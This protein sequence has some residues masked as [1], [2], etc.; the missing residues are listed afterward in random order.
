MK[1]QTK[2]DSLFKKAVELHQSSQHEQAVVLY[3]EVLILNAKHFDALQLLATLHA[4]NAR[5][6]LSAELFARAIEV[7]D[8]NPKV[9]NNYGY[10]LA[11]IGDTRSAQLM[12]E[13]AVKIDSNYLDALNNLANLYQQL[14]SYDRAVELYDRTTKINS[15][16]VQAY[17]NKGIALQKLSRFS[18]SLASYDQAIKLKPDYLDAYLNKALVLKEMGE[19][20]RALNLYSDLLKN[21]TGPQSFDI[22]N[23]CGNLLQSMGN[24]E[25]ALSH[26]DQAVL[27]N[28]YQAVT[29]S[30]RGNVLQRLKRYQEAVLSYV[31]ALT[32]DPQN[33]DFYNNRGNAHQN[34][35]ALELAL[36]DYESAIEFTPDH[37]Q[38]YY[39]MGNLFKLKREFATAIKAYERAIC[40]EP[41]YSDAYNN[42]GNIYKD[43]HQLMSAVKAYDLAIE[44][45]P[46]HL[47]ATNNKGVALQKLMDFEGAKKCFENAIELNPQNSKSYVNKAIVLFLQGK[48][49]EGWSFYE[50]RLDDSELV[51]RPLVSSK[52]QLIHTISAFIPKHAQLTKSRVL[53]WSEQGVGDIVMYASMFNHL[54]LHV[55][56][57][58]VLIDK[59]LI[60]LFER[61]FTNVSFK[62]K[63]MAVDPASYDLHLPIASIGYFLEMD[64]AKIKTLHHPYL[65]AD[66]GELEAIKLQLESLKGIGASTPA[67]AINCGIS[68]H[69]QNPV[70]GEERTL[71]ADYLLKSL[72]IDGVNF[73]NLQYTSPASLNH[74]KPQNLDSLNAQGLI[75]TDVDNFSELDRLAALISNCDLVISVDNSTVHLS[76]SLGVP[77]W[78]LLPLVPDWRW[79]LERA[80]SPWYPCVRLFRQKHWGDWSSA[81]EEIKTAL[82]VL[83]SLNSNQIL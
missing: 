3:G 37:P 39:N 40:L 65:K 18:D 79:M 29:Y 30:N 7:N 45:D 67:R 11:Q 16:Y 10:V 55:K 66:L 15:S 53:V 20:L 42:L 4:H 33:S 46:L 41:R 75:T 43:Q 35:S 17:F 62:D 27:A 9:L 48:L 54:S 57:L 68:W 76:A 60:A 44:F 24:L 23:N 81:L 72:K 70:N 28:P 63:D 58:T 19:P 32:I 6:E 12:Y 82:E 31:V 64:E 73:I 47:D 8:T 50:K 13:R 78:V 80:D 49:L 21:I 2:I 14:G 61:S 22:Y 36:R 56:E 69:S 51:P 26:F 59:R 38:A 52:P 83:V 1:D 34:M 5:F 74:H 25:D 71:E 77:T